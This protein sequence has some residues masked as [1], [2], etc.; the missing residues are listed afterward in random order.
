MKLEDIK[1]GM[2]VSINS[3]SDYYY[4]WVDEE[5]VTVVGINYKNGTK[6]VDVTIED[7]GILSDGWTLEELDAV[8]EE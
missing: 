3:E 6:I 7:D 8:V 1:L 5:D 4:D 2:K